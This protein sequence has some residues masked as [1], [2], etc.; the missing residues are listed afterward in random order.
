M[1]SHV[2]STMNRI[3]ISQGRAHYPGALQKHRP[4]DPGSPA[5]DRFSRGEPGAVPLSA[6]RLRALQGVSVDAASG[7]MEK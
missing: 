3:R 1:T 7:K 5:V 4:A 2:E 6:A